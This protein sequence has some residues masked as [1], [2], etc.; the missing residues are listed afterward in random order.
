MNLVLAD[1]TPKRITGP[2][3]I[4]SGTLT[5]DN[6]AR[7][8]LFEQSVIARTAHMTMYADRMLVHHDKESGNVTRID[9]SGTV[10]VTTA[11][12][13]ITSRDAVYYAGE[14]KIVFTGEPKAVEG[15]NMVTGTK[16]TYFMNE[17]R[18]LVEG[19]RVI[20]TN[21]KEQ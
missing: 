2:I 18:F 16:M 7:T 6:L 12:R 14:E 8:A 10:R 21:K 15:E 5:A 1:N 13:V 9:V 3:T 20:L 11:N 17:D 19:S 4:T